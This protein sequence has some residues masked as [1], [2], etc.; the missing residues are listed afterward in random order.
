MGMNEW[1]RKMRACLVGGTLVLMTGCATYQVIPSHLEDRVRT[2]LSFDEVRR[3]PDAHEGDLVMWGGK[4]LAV[5]RTEDK[6]TIEILH[7]PLDGV[8]CPIDAPT[9]SRGRYM[10]VDVRHE[11]ESPSSLPKDTLVTVIGE[12]HGLINASLDQGQYGYPHITIRDMTAWEKQTGL[13]H[14]APGVQMKGY[15]P[16]VFWDSRRVVGRDK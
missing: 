8:H 7:L 5:N 14:S 3:N 10:A 9:A 6:T 12:V 13:R 4:V 15:R 2:E 11:I 1:V 16:F